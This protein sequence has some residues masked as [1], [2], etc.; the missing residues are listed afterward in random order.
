MTRY[1]ADSSNG[2]RVVNNL[3]VEELPRGCITRL[4]ISLIHNG[5]GDPLYIPALVMR[6]R[7]D[8]PVF[9]LTA[10]MHGNELNGIPVI[11][12]L[13]DKLDC[14]SLR[15][16]I[17]AIPVV[18]IPGYLEKIRF[19][20]DGVD[21]NKIMPGD[22]NG[23]VSGIYAFR[24]ADR[25]VKHFNYLVDLHTASFGRINSLYVRAD[26]THEVTA[27]MALLQRPQII[28]HNTPAD[29]TLRGHAMTLG[30]PAI[31][32]EIGNPHLFQP[33]YIRRSLTGLNAVLGEVGMIPKR[34]RSPSPLPVLCSRS[35]WL[36]SD[37]GGILEVAP[38]V[39][40]VVEAGQ[41][42]AQISNVYGDLVHEYKSR[43]TGIVIGKSTNPVGQTGARIM[44]L[45]IKASEEEHERYY[46]G[47]KAQ[48][49]VH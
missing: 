23:N 6:G 24:F 27:K 20:N 15:G 8:G 19:F 32:L 3:N 47:K 30:I 34:H 21:L 49:S 4:R 2:P 18:N 36:Y 10:A 48:A 44:H 16:T 39:T 11:H 38:N 14:N 9:G 37:H 41:V 25:I 7:K 26:M 29:G 5:L 33:E 42:V 12:R 31:T 35:Y 46:M 28:L 43:D 17:V 1:G 45:G 40:E 13:F 22:P